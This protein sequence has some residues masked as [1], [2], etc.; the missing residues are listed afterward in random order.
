[1]IAGFVVHKRL[2]GRLNYKTKIMITVSMLFTAS[3]LVAIS[4]QN[5]LCGTHTKDARVDTTCGPKDLITFFR[6]CI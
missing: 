5:A 2:Q 4:F 6:S 3:C 1:M